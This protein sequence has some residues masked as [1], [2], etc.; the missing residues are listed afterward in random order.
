MLSSLLKWVVSADVTSHKK[1]LEE[2]VPTS[3][4]TSVYSLKLEILWQQRKF[5]T[6]KIQPLCGPLVG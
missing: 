5:C 6:T 2:T 4:D 3:T 1:V